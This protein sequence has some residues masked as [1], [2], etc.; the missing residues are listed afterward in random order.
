MLEFLTP[1]PIQFQLNLNTNNERVNSLCL[2]NLVADTTR[3]L[4]LRY[5]RVHGTRVGQQQQGRTRLRKSL[6]P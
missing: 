1:L 4:V 3:L 5:D 2:F 6:V